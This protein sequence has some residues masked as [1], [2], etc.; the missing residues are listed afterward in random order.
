[1]THRAVYTQRK[2]SHRRLKMWRHH[3]AAAWEHC[4]RDG[5]TFLV[6]FFYYSFSNSAAVFAL[7]CMAEYRRFLLG[8]VEKYLGHEMPAE[9]SEIFLLHLARGQTCRT[10]VGAN[11]ACRDR[12][13]CCSVPNTGSAFEHSCPWKG[14]DKPWRL[15]PGEKQGCACVRVTG[16]AEHREL[17]WGSTEEIPNSCFATAVEEKRNKEGVKLSG[18]IWSLASKS[19]AQLTPCLAAQLAGVRRG[20]WVFSE[21]AMPEHMMDSNYTSVQSITSDSLV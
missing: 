13:Q 4:A 17:V 18:I 19:A 7:L 8:A 3:T 2:Y 15:R 21:E 14:L 9:G 20:L 10:R 5:E 11:L 12:T 16:S 1:M 6:F